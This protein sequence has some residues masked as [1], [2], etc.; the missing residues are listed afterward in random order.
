MR[1]KSYVRSLIGFQYFEKGYNKG[2]NWDNWGYMNMDII[3][4]LYQ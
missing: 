2:H 1:N 3:I 4:L